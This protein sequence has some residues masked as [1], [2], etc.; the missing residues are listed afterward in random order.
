[1]Y[2]LTYTI[3]ANHTTDPAQVKKAA[4][5]IMS[6]YAK[7]YNPSATLEDITG[8]ISSPVF[9]HLAAALFKAEQDIT[10]VQECVM[11]SLAAVEGDTTNRISGKS[12]RY[13]RND[14][15]SHTFI[16]QCFG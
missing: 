11:W 15:G 4:A 13:S 9:P 6:S 8:T 10:N 5:Y 2:T 16:I 12:H 14:D 1:M 3:P 7:A